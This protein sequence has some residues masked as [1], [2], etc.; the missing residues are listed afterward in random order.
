MGFSVG[1]ELRDT[2][3][4]PPLGCVEGKRIEFCKKFG[5]HSPGLS[6]SEWAVYLAVYHSIPPVTM[7]LRIYTNVF[8]T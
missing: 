4:A 2:Q 1:Y 5:G 3:V 7:Y 8:N 6:K